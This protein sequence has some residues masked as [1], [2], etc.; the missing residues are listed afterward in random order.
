MVGESFPPVRVRNKVC[1][2][3][4]TRNVYGV[5]ELIK[6]GANKGVVILRPNWNLTWPSFKIQNLD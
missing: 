3:L 5:K 6:Y 2:S 1:G 4:C